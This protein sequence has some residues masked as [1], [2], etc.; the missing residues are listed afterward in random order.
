[1]KIK[2]LYIILWHLCH[3]YKLLL[4]FDFLFIRAVAPKVPQRLLLNYSIWAKRFLKNFDLLIHFHI[5]TYRLKKNI[6]YIHVTRSWC[7]FID[8][9]TFR[10]V[11]H[12]WSPLFHS[13]HFTKPHQWRNIHIILFNYQLSTISKWIIKAPQNVSLSVTQRV[14]EHLRVTEHQRVAEH[15]V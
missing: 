5:S 9:S 12:V 15:S 13:L 4:L 3:L 11:N 8:N 7:L 6:E 2:S 14:T 10:I 1:M